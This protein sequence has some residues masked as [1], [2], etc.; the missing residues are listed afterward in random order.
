MYHHG[1]LEHCVPVLIDIAIRR[2]ILVRVIEEE[3]EHR[4]KNFKEFVRNHSNN[5]GDEMNG[6][7]LFENARSKKKKRN[8]R[9]L[10]FHTTSFDNFAICPCNCHNH[11][12][13]AHLVINCLNQLVDYP[14]IANFVTIDIHTGT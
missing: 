14:L 6:S 11:G 12:Y 1:L 7:L 10:K 3:G 9:E 8:E 13:L 4:N 5:K 2:I